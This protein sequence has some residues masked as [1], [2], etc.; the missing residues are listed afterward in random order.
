MRRKKA[1]AGLL[2]LSLCAGISLHRIQA[3]SFGGFE[4]DVEEGEDSQQWNEE[5]MGSATEGENTEGTEASPDQNASAPSVAES[6]GNNG[7]AES[8]GGG[9]TENAGGKGAESAGGGNAGNAGDGGTKSTGGGNSGSIGGG[10]TGSGGTESTGGGKTGS[11]G[12]E[13]AR[14]G[15]T[16]NAGSGETES[17]GSRGKEGARGGGMES[18][19]GGKAG[20]TGRG[21]KESAGGEKTESTVGDGMES[22]GNDG[23]NPVSPE[24]SAETDRKKHP[25]ESSPENAGSVTGRADRNSSQLAA[26]GPVIASTGISLL[27]APLKYYNNINNNKKKNTKYKEK[28]TEKE[29]FQDITGKA[30]NGM[31]SIT[32]FQ[33]VDITIVSLRLNSQEAS[34]HWAEGKIFLDSPVSKKN[35]TVEMVVLV[36]GSQILFSPVWEIL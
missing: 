23:K 7:G 33:D 32:L 17:A 26:A 16:G 13:S 35:S 1:V 4:I 25:E 9:R 14:G 10:K 20:N 2:I 29:I 36:N 3:G 15:K 34:W 22:T 6:A 27:S 12:T 5:D 31:V 11:G 28:Y 19:G 8:A 21:E 24:V 30:E 18:N